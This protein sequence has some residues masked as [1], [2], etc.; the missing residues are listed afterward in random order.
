MYKYCGPENPLDNELIE[1]CMK[2]G[3][4]DIHS[5]KHNS[6]KLMK[7]IWK[8]LNQNI[9]KKKIAKICN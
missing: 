6:D 3:Y 1:I 2:H 4:F 9:L 8:N 7:R 5:N